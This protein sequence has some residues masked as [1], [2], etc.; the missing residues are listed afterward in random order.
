[1][2]KSI[3]KNGRVIGVYKSHAISIELEI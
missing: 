3:V 2:F 1:M